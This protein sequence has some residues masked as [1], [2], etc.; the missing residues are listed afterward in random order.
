M[1][2][3]TIAASRSASGMRHSRA[4]HRSGVAGTAVIAVALLVVGTWQVAAEGPLVAWDWSFHLYADTRHPDGWD[5]D[6]LDWVASVTGER[7]FTI[8]AVGGVAVWVA[9]R[10]DRVRPLVATAAGLA[11]IAVVGYSIKFG[12][13][14]AAPWTGVD[15]LYAGGRAFPSGHAA[16]ATFTW[17]FLVILVFGALGL[18]PDRLRLSLWLVPA[19]LVALVSGTL[20]ALLDYHWL[21]DIPGGWVLGA[22][23]VA[24]ALGVLRSPDPRLE[25]SPRT[26]LARLR[27]RAA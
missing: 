6:A 8:P 19:F 21:S 22:L 5:K 20:M 10:Q 27:G 7:L 3:Q 1:T 16:N 2:S 13:G 23:A 4:W 9:Y 18:R 12:L 11:T 15:A 26:L 25:T 17:I 24:V 14:R